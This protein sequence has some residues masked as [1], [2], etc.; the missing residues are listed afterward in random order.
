MA[1]AIPAALACLA[2]F[3]LG[4]CEESGSTTAGGGGGGTGSGTGSGTFTLRP[5]TL[6]TKADLNPIAQA[7]QMFEID[8]GRYPTD[9]EG[10]DALLSADAIEEGDASKWQGPYLQREQDL[11]DPYGNRVE[12]ERDGEGFVLR[13][14][15]SDGQPGGTGS[16]QDIEL[17]K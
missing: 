5:Q 4:A 7:V 2:A 1:R 15:G 17:R 8:M 12:Y 16:M 14:L 11:N 3:A 9:A 13:S 10:L 6:T